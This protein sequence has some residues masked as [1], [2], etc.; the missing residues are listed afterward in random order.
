M[1]PDP[2][3]A[4]GRP[5]KP[6]SAP[7]PEETDEDLFD[8]D[9]LAKISTQAAAEMRKEL[10]QALAD[11]E[12][13][14]QEVA[15]VVAQAAA[16]PGAPPLAPA[17]AAPLV[18]RLPSVKPADAVVHQRLS[19]SPLAGALLVAVVAANLVLMLFAWRS[20]SATRQLV[21][22][23]ASEMRDTTTDLRDESARRSEIAALESEPVFGALPEGYR[24]LR[25][26]RER[27][28]RGEH[29]RAR[30]MLYGLL[31]VVD[32]LEQ[33]ARGEV[34]AQASFLVADSLRLE[35][36]ALRDPARRGEAR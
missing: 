9:E 32:R 28:E 11:V 34:E 22:D 24:T 17:R 5:S 8:F 18:P 6:A 14:V 26:A 4:A 3:Q 2:T 25:I 29:S 35:A 10:E 20:V 16:A 13:T 36:D 33:P 12:Q 31:A 21:F 19:L 30:R 7:P 1:K 15:P 23:V 27:L